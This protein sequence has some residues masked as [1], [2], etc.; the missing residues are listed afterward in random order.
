[1]AAHR[2]GKVHAPTV[3][4]VVVGHGRGH[5][6]FGH[7][8]VRLAEERLADEANRHSAR[9]RFNRGTQPRAA[10]ADDENIVAVTLKGRHQMSLTSV[11]MPIE[12]RR[13]YTSASATEKRLIQAKS[14]CRPLSALEQL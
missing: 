3:A 4:V 11:M 5:A 14:M 12:Q 8:G 13:T 6:A 1:A 9:G 2:V 10:G 7:H